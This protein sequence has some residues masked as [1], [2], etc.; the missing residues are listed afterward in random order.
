MGETVKLRAADGFELSAY[1][2]PPQAKPKGGLVV[3]QEIFGVNG[4]IR[5]V[6]DGFAADGFLAVAPALFDRIGP[7]ITLG[8]SQDEI[9]EGIGLKGQSSTENTLADIAAARDFVKDAGKTGVIGYCWGGFL[10]WVSA[11]RLPGFA[12]AVSYYGGGIGGVAEEKPRCPVLMHF[13]EK[14]HAIPLTDVDKVRAAQPTGVEIHVYPA[15]HGFNCDERGSYD[16]ES[17]KAARERTVAFLG[18][19]LR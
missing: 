13:G 10:A 5:R 12:A 16:A 18:R 4:H 9:Q 11:T 19:H 8:Y 2:A 1:V 7:G 15:G 17:A 6:A 14:D 3:V